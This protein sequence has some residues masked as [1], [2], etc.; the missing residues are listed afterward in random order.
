M[1]EERWL[2]VKSYEGRYEVSNY[3]KVRSLVNPDK[4]VVLK[5]GR[6]SSG[7]LTVYLYDGKSPS[8]GKS[9]LLHLLVMAAF[10]KPGLPGQTQCNHKDLDKSNNHI[11]NL[12]WNTPKENVNHA[13]EA[14]IG[15]GERHSRCRL[16]DVDIAK[17]RERIASGE[18]CSSIAVDYK[19]SAGY[20]SQLKRNL[21]RK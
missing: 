9:Y 17:I 11:D 8:K 1:L 20:V 7:Y 13:I 12:E 2:A 18:V 5:P 16:S 21:Y 4:Q 3:G 6:Q 19:I 15:V 10:G 14:G